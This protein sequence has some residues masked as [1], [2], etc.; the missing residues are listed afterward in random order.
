M[1][2]QTKRE[3]GQVP[4]GITLGDR[5][6]VMP[7]MFGLLFTHTGGV[8]RDGVQPESYA[9]IQ[10]GEVIARYWVRRPKTNSALLNFFLGD[11]LTFYAPIVSPVSGLVIHKSFDANRD[12]DLGDAPPL[13]YFAVLLPD[14]E[15]PPLSGE[16]MFGPAVRLLNDHRDMLMKPSRMW[17]IPAWEPAKVDE[18]FKRQL[19]A[20]CRA[21]PAMPHWNDYFEEART[22]HPSLRPHLRHLFKA[23][24]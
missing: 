23:T 16:E 20:K 24:A 11:E 2:G 21:Y 4:A 17:T 7:S 8:T 22:R 14:D 1:S 5:V 9:W 12:V 15:P 10:R 18:L 6:L 19:S 3:P 13:A